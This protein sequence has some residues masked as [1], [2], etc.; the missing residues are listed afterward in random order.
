[1]ITPEQIVKGA[2]A[3]LAMI[4][5]LYA[6]FKGRAKWEPHDQDV[7]KGAQRFG[8]LGACVLVVLILYFFGSPKYAV[9]V[10]AIMVVVLI[11]GFLS[12]QTYQYLT[13]SLIYELEK[14]TKGVSGRIKVL[15]GERQDLSV[16]AQ[17]EIKR[18]ATVQ[19][20]VEGCG[21]DLEKI[22]PQESRA[23]TKQKYERSY[24]LMIICGTTALACVG[25]FFSWLYH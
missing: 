21:G 23:K 9:V 11:V 7:P 2:T 10:A 15:G 6:G 13:S 14:V 4:G 12:Y 1:M 8:S 18:G 25:I 22:W 24:T 3:A 17:K 5:A 19:E 16:Q 20:L